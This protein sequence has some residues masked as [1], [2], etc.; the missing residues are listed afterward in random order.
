MGKK[1]L[2]WNL[3]LFNGA[4]LSASGLHCCYGL[5]DAVSVVIVIDRLSEKYLV[6]VIS[7]NVN[8]KIPFLMP[9]LAPLT[10][11]FILRG[12]AIR[13]VRKNGSIW[14][15]IKQRKK[16]RLKTHTKVQVL[17]ISLPLSPPHTPHS[18]SCSF[19][20]ILRVTAE[21]ID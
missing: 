14:G 15:T 4:G 12:S 16:E 13:M 20:K 10:I 11:R 3:F 7:G 8:V 5:L 6:F 9:C 2:V 1:N 19:H 18:L 17:Q 21:C